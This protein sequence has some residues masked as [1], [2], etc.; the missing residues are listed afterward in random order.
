MDRG[1]VADSIL[2]SAGRALRAA[3]SGRRMSLRHVEGLSR[4]R[5]KASALGSYERG[6]RAISLER[7]CELSLLY[8]FPPQRLLADALGE[9]RRTGSTVVDL[10]RLSAIDAD[11]AEAVSRFAEGIVAQRRDRGASG[12]SLRS[13]D[14]ALLVTS[15]GLPA[16]ELT[17]D[18]SFSEQ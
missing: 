4:G 9:S 2:V 10:E 16:S 1:A 6:E 5:F 3:R 13:G 17:E 12:V 18:L 11:M 8:G 15:T 14:V 7:F